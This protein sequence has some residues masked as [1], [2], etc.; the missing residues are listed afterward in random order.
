M[1]DIEEWTG[2]V[3]GG[4]TMVKAIDRLLFG[5]CFGIGFAI[6]F[7]VLNFIGSFLHAP[8]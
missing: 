1:S 2:E 3:E 4:E 5:L 8:H 6:A 7:N